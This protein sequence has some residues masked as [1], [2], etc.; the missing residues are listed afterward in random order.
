MENRSARSESQTGGQFSAAG[1]LKDNARGV[2]SSVGTSISD[3]A[4]RGREAVSTAADNAV[5]TAGTDL[6]ALQADF[7]RLKETVTKFMTQAA[8]GATKSARD[9]SSN[10]AGRVGDFAGDVAQRG[11]AIASGATDQA[12]SLAAEL[13]NM[14]RRNPIGALAGAVM[15]GV[16]IGM[17]GRRS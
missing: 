5:N 2:G 15:I 17:L 7:N 13:E 6:Q 11:S 12:K 16:L 1:Q 10:V 9:I 4:A 14:A 8:D 3:T